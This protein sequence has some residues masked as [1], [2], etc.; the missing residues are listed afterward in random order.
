MCML[1]EERHGTPTGCDY[2]C[3]A[4]GAAEKR[5]QNVNNKALEYWRQP[6]MTTKAVMDLQFTFAVIMK[7]NHLK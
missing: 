7:G 4:F 5:L 2:R 1:S 3:A 6:A